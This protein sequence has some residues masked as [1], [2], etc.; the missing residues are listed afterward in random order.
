M[1]REKDA[2]EQLLLTVRAKSQEHIRLLEGQLQRLQDV[3][4][5]KMHE[6]SVT[7]D[8]QLPLRAELEAFRML[9]EREEARY[10]ECSPA[11]KMVLAPVV[12][13][14]VARYCVVAECWLVAYPVVVALS[15]AYRSSSSVDCLIVC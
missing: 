6:L 12:A 2:I 8:S 9:L 11:Y 14:S 13:C 15:L 1:E 7:R 4:V 10:C 3:L 5:V